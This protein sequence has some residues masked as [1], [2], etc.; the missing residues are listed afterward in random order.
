M[1][2]QDD[3]KSEKIRTQSRRMNQQGGREHGAKSTLRE[4]VMA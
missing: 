2:E 3:E 4:K 1:M